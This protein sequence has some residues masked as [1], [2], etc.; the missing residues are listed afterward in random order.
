MRVTIFSDVHGDIYS[1]EK[2]FNIEKSDRY[3]SLGD[4]VGYGPFPND[5]ID[6]AFDKCGPENLIMGNHEAM[7]LDGKAHPGCSE[8][9]RRFFEAS[10]QQYTTDDRIAKFKESIKLC[11]ENG[12]VYNL[13]HTL[14][15]QH[16]YPNSNISVFFGNNIIGHSHIQFYLPLKS[17]GFIINTGS[18]GQNRIDKN[19]ANYINLDLD[20]GAIQ[21][22]SFFSCKRKIISDMIN[23]GYNRD[24]VRYYEG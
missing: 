14:N 13:I 19:I 4:L 9:A 23:L 2:L 6:L 16:I 18:L 1:L 10:Y 3:I 20:S 15:E 21:Y 7:F 12:S 11:L 22:K 8:L 24:I 17:E 5:C